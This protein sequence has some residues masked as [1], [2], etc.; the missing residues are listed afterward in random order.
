MVVKCKECDKYASFGLPGTKLGIY[1][2]LHK[3]DGYINVNN[4]CCQHENCPHTPCFGKLGSRQPKFCRIHKPD[5]Y[6]DVKNKR[7]LHEN[8][9]QIPSF[10]KPGSKK[11]DYCNSHKPDG[12]I[13]VM[14]KRC[15][16][17]ECKH[18]PSFGKQGTKTAIFC[19]QH[20]PSDYIDVISRYCLYE[21]CNHRPSFGDPNIKKAVY[22]FQ[23]KPSGYIDVVHKKCQYENCNTIPNYNYIGYS[24]IYCNTH[25][26]SGMILNPIKR[27]I[28]HKRTL[29]T[30][31][32]DKSFY[33]G[34][35][36]KEHPNAFE[37]HETCSI[38]CIKIPKDT[39]IC[40]ACD[41]TCKTG[42]TVKRKQKEEAMKEF[43]IKNN[44]TFIHDV[45]VENGCSGKRPDFQIVTNWGYIIIEVDEYQHIRKSYACECEVQRMKQIY[46][47]LGTNKVVFVRFNPDDYQPSYGKV[48]TCNKRYEF[49]FKRLQRIINDTKVIPLSVHYLFYDGFSEIDNVEDVIDPYEVTIKTPSIHF[50]NLSGCSLNVQEES[51][52]QDVLR[53]KLD[54]K[55]KVLAV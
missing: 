8:C 5:D 14:S 23:H 11:R 27:C 16:Y 46:H 20:K 24:P 35:C 6:V 43:L 21:N 1:C 29:A 13:N 19:Q 3:L 47:D 39:N 32:F 9:N 30:H 54:I 34:T 15:Q 17:E 7:C 2:K 44:Y 42:Q 10:G 55:K 40:Q 53:I 4:K 52:K 36:A 50:S 41:T 26:S 51:K 12:Y 45:R 48:F 33:C 18:L 28:N 49:L 31:V 37:I 25:K 38:C 22:C